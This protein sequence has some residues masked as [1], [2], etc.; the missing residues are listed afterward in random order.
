MQNLIIIKSQRRFVQI[1]GWLAHNFSDKICEFMWI[2][3]KSL[4]LVPHNVESNFE[5]DGLKSYWIG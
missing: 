4:E 2:A 3:G 5:R 1:R